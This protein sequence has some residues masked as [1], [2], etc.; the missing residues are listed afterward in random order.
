MR[1]LPDIISLDL[2]KW[3]VSSQTQNEN[4]IKDGWLFQSLLY[5]HKLDSISARFVSISTSVNWHCS[6]QVNSAWPLFVAFILLKK[7]PVM[8]LSKTFSL[9]VQQLACYCEDFV[10]NDI[11]TAEQ[12]LRN[13]EALFSIFSQLAFR[14]NY[15]Y[16]H[17]VYGICSKSSQLLLI[18]P[19]LQYMA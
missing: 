2:L 18:E 3:S 16:L 9:L 5:L 15:C 13:K 19:L 1:G 14:I 10:L 17:S 7:K 12:C 11:S 8:P 4:C 6:G